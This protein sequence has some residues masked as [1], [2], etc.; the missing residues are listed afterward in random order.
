[1]AISGPGAA[2]TGVPVTFVASLGEEPFRTDWTAS[3]GAAA[4]HSPAFTVSFAAPG[5]YSV[6]LTA[7]FESGP[8]SATQAVAVGGASCG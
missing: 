1:V 4:A 3:S 2:E 7:L 6:T 8:L 5:C